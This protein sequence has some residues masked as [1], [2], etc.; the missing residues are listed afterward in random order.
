MELVKYRCFFRLMFSKIFFTHTSTG[1]AIHQDTR[2]IVSSEDSPHQFNET[3]VH[4]HEHP[5]SSRRQVLYS[6]RSNTACD[7]RRNLPL[8]FDSS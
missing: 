4:L 1:R 7:A 2:Q 3:P 5:S 8:L 6:Y